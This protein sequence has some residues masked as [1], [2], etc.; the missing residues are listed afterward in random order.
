[1]TT[2]NNQTEDNTQKIHYVSVGMTEEE[3]NQL[4]LD[5]IERIKTV[6]DLYGAFYKIAE[7]AETEEDQQVANGLFIKTLDYCHH[8]IVEENQ[9]NQPLHAE[10]GLSVQEALGVLGLIQQDFPFY[11]HPTLEVFDANS[12]DAQKPASTSVGVLKEMETKKQSTM[13]DHWRQLV[14]EGIEPFEHLRTASEFFD[15][16]LWASEL[17]TELGS[18]AQ[19]VMN[20]DWCQDVEQCGIRIEQQLDMP[21]QPQY[22]FDAQEALNVLGHIQRWFSFYGREDIQLSEAPPK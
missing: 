1:M 7:T 4:V 15:C 22:E 14:S 6:E 13:G 10:D 8:F 21:L 16:W 9:P 17:A 11:D 20:A 3:E 5:I 18:E 19:E 2:T 12:E